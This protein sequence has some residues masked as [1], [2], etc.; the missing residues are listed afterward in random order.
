M[1]QEQRR[2]LAARAR[3]NLSGGGVDPVRGESWEKIGEI[4]HS[5]S[6]RA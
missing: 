3:E 2:P 5:L 1:Q 4:G 6:D